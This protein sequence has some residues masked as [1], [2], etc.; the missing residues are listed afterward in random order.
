MS[1]VRNL[2]HD[3]FG[4]LALYIVCKEILFHI[5]ILLKSEQYVTGLALPLGLYSNSA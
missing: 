5:K 4:L 1:L 2:Y 3:N